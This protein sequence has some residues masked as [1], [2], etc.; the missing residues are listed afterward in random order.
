MPGVDGLGEADLA[1]PRAAVD[2]LGGVLQDEDRSL[3]RRAAH[4]GRGD[5]PSQH[6]MLGDA[7]IVEETIGRLRRRP[8]AAC[9]R[10]RLAGR[11]RHL[12]K[13]VAQPARQA[14]VRQPRRIDCIVMPACDAGFR[15]PAHL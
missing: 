13:P 12:I 4:G 9:R 7:R 10:D 1:R 11:R 2:E 6:P 3:A 8:V 14:F 15:V 5:M